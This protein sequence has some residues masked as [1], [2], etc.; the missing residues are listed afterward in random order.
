MS[1]S[2]TC[3]FDD[4]THYQAAYRGAFVTFVSTGRGPFAA[5]RTRITLRHL[6]L[7]RAEETSSRVAFVV[8]PPA[9]AFV[10]FSADPDRPLIWGGR[11]LGPGELILHGSSERLHQRTDGPSCWGFISLTAAALS[12]A[13]KVL[14]G[15]RRAHAVS[16]QILLPPERERAHLLRIHAE[17]V[18]LAQTKPEVL[19]HPEVIRAMEQELTG[20][21][22]ACLATSRVRT[23]SEPVRYNAKLVT[24]FEGVVAANPRRMVSPAELRDATG[25]TDRALR[26]GCEA[27]L[28][29]APRHYMRLRRLSLVRDAI[30][31]ADPAAVRL[32]ELI[33]QGGFVDYH[34]FA[35][36]YRNAFGETPSATR[37]RMASL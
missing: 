4:E 3:N 20:L 34:S 1:G 5:R 14:T 26:Q 25:A 19:S 29:V 6:H 30:L 12:E 7:L 9:I 16:S 10:S 24:C 8:L 36:M 27:V 28:G 15:H 22:V 35:L 33:G 23:E 37:R 31:H 18:N 13:F 11:P 17:A 32:G 2:A 21:L